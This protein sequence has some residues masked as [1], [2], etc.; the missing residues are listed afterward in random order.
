MHRLDSAW[1]LY[2][3][4]PAYSEDR[5]S[6]DKK[7]Y[8]RYGPFSSVDG[9]WNYFTHFPAPSIVLCDENGSKRLVDD[10]VPEG[11]ALF[12]E[13]VEPVWE[14][15]R[16]IK[17]GHWELREEFPEE[18]ADRIWEEVVMGL[19]G[20]TMEEGRHITGA[21]MID[22]TRHHKR[23]YRIEVW[24]DTTE[25]EIVYPIRRKLGSEIIESNA[26]KW[27]NH[28]VSVNDWRSK[29]KVKKP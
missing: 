14:D 28:A 20:E 17:G 26:W 27:Q 7:P 2:I 13:G 19:I 8:V 22:K 6:E 10:Q 1:N 23:A 16:N 18:E 9:F 5:L 29:I 24:I 3:T 25:R 21:R 11:I 12:K 15:P 4:L